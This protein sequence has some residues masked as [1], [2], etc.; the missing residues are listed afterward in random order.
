MNTAAAKG[1]KKLPVPEALVVAGHGLEGDA[2]AGGERQVSLLA[3]ESVDRAAAAGMELKPGDFGENLTVQGLDLCAMGVGQRLLAGGEAILQV[4]GI[5]KIC[6][7]PCSIG[8]RLGKCVMP[9]E[10]VFAKAVKGGRVRPG[11]AVEPTTVKAGAALTSSDRCARGEREDESGRLLVEL[12]RELGIAV[13]DYSVLPDDEALLSEKLKFLADRCGVDLVLTTGGTGLAP[14]DRMPEATLAVLD[15]PAPGISEALR[16]E[17]MRHTPFACLSRGVSG[18]RGRT[19]I[20][21]LPGS[22]SAITESAELLRAILPHALEI[23]RAEAGDCG[24]G[25]QPHH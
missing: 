4:S 8:Q 1:D 20:I 18:L 9:S 19:L 3:Q 5:G 12:L 10:G 7:K 15:S 2:H 22:S 11:D 25:R 13:A 24:A 6:E 16:E 17:G 23:I 14:R 21:N